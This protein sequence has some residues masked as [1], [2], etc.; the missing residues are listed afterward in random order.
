MFKEKFNLKFLIF[1]LF[2]TAS[3]NFKSIDKFDNI[4]ICAAALG[5]FGL[6]NY[7]SGEFK[8][9]RKEL[10]L[11]DYAILATLSSVLIFLNKKSILK[12][13]KKSENIGFKSFKQRYFLNFFKEL[14]KI[15]VVI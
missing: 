13:F 9:I 11:L 2:L 6:N 5:F 12:I 14:Q 10:D 8:G 4:F 7:Q 15:K 3:L 1:F